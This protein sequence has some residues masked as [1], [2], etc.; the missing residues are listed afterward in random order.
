MPGLYGSRYTLLG[1]LPFMPV[2]RILK[3]VAGGIFIPILLLLIGT[4]LLDTNV[5]FVRPIGN[6]MFVAVDWP[7]KIFGPLFTPSPNCVCDPTLKPPDA[8]CDP[9]LILPP[10]SAMLAS[11]AVDFIV[12]A[13]LTYFLLSVFRKRNPASP[14]VIESI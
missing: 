13:T 9:T 4:I 10:L 14:Q 7:L 8:C 5:R 12:Y 11:F 3:T 2:N 6:F 1:G